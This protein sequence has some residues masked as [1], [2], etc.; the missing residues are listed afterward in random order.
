MYNYNIKNMK[1]QN[2]LKAGS[3][4]SPSHKSP[5]IARKLSNEQ[6]GG[7]YDLGVTRSQIS[8]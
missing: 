4:I 2:K 6:E 5:R 1:L 8:V 7:T 3:K